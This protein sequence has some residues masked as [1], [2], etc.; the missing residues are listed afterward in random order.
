M[1][2]FEERSVSWVWVLLLINF[3]CIV[4]FSLMTR[5]YLQ[6]TNGPQ[7]EE[8][9]LPLIICGIVITVLG[10]VTYAFAGYRVAFDGEQLTFG[11]RRW[12]KTLTVDHIAIAK[13]EPKIGLRFGGFGWRIDLRGRL[14]YIA[15]GGDAVEVTTKVHRRYVFSCNSP[16][17]LLKSLNAAGVQ[18]SR[19]D[20]GDSA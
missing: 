5:F 10:V 17:E 1:T 13:R 4:L 8:L 15:S 18:D 20:S 19:H 7:S 14:G 12:K 3:V 2:Y 6:V 9:F 16:D 11:F